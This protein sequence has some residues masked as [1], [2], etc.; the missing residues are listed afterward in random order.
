MKITEFYQALAQKDL[1]DV[2]GL[3]EAYACA[4]SELALVTHLMPVQGIENFKSFFGEIH[5]YYRRT[6][7]IQ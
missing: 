5:F 3:A 7:K 1:E 2:V 4:V 6:A